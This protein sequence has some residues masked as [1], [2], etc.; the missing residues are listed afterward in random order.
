[1]K[2]HLLICRTDALG[3]SVLTLPVVHDLRTA[4]PDAHI[5]YCGR[6]LT[7][8]LLEAC[9]D[10]DQ[11]LCYP[12]HGN[13]RAFN[14]QLFQHSFDAA[15]M[16]Y[17]K[18]IALAWNLARHSIPIRVGTQRRWWGFLYNHRCHRSRS[19]SHLHESTI[20]QRTCCHRH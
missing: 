15:I 4:F 6:R 7:Q 16:C 8:P 20:E 1:M 18:P 19:Q 9:P 10:I 3:D 12:E 2:P 13:R 11:V 17:P 5:S 14:Q